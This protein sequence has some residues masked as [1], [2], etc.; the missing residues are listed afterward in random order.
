M[1]FIYLFLP[2]KLPD[3]KLYDSCQSI[4]SSFVNTDAVSA[5]SPGHH[6]T[7]SMTPIGISPAGIIN[8]LGIIVLLFLCLLAYHIGKKISKHVRAACNPNYLEVLRNKMKK[9]I[10]FH[11]KEIANGH[12]QKV[13]TLPDILP[14]NSTT[15]TPQI[16]EINSSL[17]KE[18]FY[19]CEEQAQD[20]KEFPCILLVMPDR[21]LENRLKEVLATHFHTTIQEDSKILIQEMKYNA[22]TIILPNDTY[23]WNAK[24]DAAGAE[25]PIVKINKQAVPPST[26]STIPTPQK[27]KDGDFINKI[28]G[29]LE[30]NL[31]AENYTVTRLSKEAGTSRTSLYTKIKGITGTSPKEYMLSFKMEKAEKLLADLKYNV[32]DVAFLVGYAD[33]KYFGKKFKEH[34]HMCPTQYRKKIRNEVQTCRTQTG[35]ET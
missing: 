33:A 7:N 14:T 34:Y 4:F 6:A 16:P 15:N 11:T 29:L 26:S 28:N 13:A 18:P 31:N 21:N 8:S 20:R 19:S 27:E 30:K 5:G 35:T 12:F 32:A 1:K 3:M 25:P 22:H 2:V 9:I 10:P 24:K 23:S 17:V